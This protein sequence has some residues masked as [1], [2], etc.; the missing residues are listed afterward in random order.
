MRGFTVDEKSLADNLAWTKERFIP[1]P[2]EKPKLSDG[3]EIA[4]LAVPL[5]KLA[6]T[7]N[8][9]A[10]SPDEIDRMTQHVVERQQPDG[11]WVLQPRPPSPVF[12]SRET[13]TTWFYLG[14]DADAPKGAKASSAARTSRELARKW[15]E[16]RPPADTTQYWVMRLLTGVRGDARSRERGRLIKK[17]LRRQNPDGGWAQ[18]PELTSDAYA[19]G[20]AL[21]VL[22]LAGVKNEC[23]EIRRGVDFL[24]TTQLE[25]GSW[26][27]LPRA[28][29]ERQAS[30]NLWP[31]N[32][33]GAAWA[34]MGL[35]RSLPPVKEGQR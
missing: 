33:F 23:K 17:L 27:M 32:H 19:T 7:S 21:Y 24:V 20:Q 15:L 28:T 34:T 25:D 31:I 29:P 13:L 16:S 22:G 30:I 14:L 2:G 9:S 1:P 5:L 12:D 18:T 4:S 10:L 11:S 8:P 26:K 35:V 6:Q 3:F